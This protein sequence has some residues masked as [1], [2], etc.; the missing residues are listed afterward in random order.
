[1]NKLFDKAKAL[2]NRQ[3]ESGLK[4]LIN[5][6]WVF[7]ERILLLGTSFTVGIYVARFLGPTQFGTLAYALSF[8]QLF[9]AL[10]NMGLDRILV[11]EFV[12]QPESKDAIISTSFLLK[13][14][15]AIVA[16]ALV[17]L[18]TS[19]LGNDPTTILYI[20][21]IAS[22]NI[23]QAFSVLDAF[24]QS[25]VQAKYV[26]MARFWAS[27]TATGIKFALV[28]AQA[29]LVAFV[30]IYGVEMSLFGLGLLLQ[31]FRVHKHL[32]QWRPSKALARTLMRDSWPLILGGF[33]IDFY[34]RIDRIMIN[35]MLTATETGEYAVGIKLFETISFLPVVLCT[36]LFPAILNARKDDLKKYQN[37]LQ[38]LYSLM[39]ASAWAVALG[40]SLTAAWLIPFLYGE[41]YQAGVL[42]LQ[43]VA[44][45][46]VPISMGLALSQYLIAENLVKIDMMRKLVGMV[47]N[48]SLNFYM[49]PRMGIVGAAWA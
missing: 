22:G 46:L 30:I 15:G 35:E 34:S 32:W 45:T 5:T 10:A 4:Y 23:L 27:L 40:L 7:A 18:V 39:S 25:Q 13:L 36:S 26:A 48:V 11:R 2:L 29:P 38:Q 41:E 8:A 12:N 21:I 28:M 14:S 6:S 20:V 9:A 37:R 42:V 33:M 17:A 31:Y 44:F 16:I 24:F 49:I 3:G 1:M 43:I 19:G 47:T